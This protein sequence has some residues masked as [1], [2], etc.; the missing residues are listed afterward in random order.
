MFSYFEMKK[1]F[2][3]NG[4]EVSTISNYNNMIIFFVC[5][6]NNDVHYSFYGAYDEIKKEIVCCK[7]YI[8]LLM[9]WVYKN[10]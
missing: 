3:D 10:S 4:C 9:I 2:E 5:T 8:D 1:Y 7:K 6:K